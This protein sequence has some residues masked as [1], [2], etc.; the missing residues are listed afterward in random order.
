MFVLSDS[1][2]KSLIKKGELEIIPEPEGVAFQPSS[3]DLRIG[4][5]FKQ[6][7]DI[8]IIEIT[9]NYQPEDYW[10]T[11]EEVES[12]GD[13][14]TLEKNKLYVI[15]SLEKIKLSPDYF[16]EFQQRSS[17]GRRFCFANSFSVGSLDFSF[18]KFSDDKHK[19]VE[20]CI[21]PFT[22]TKIYKGQRAFQL[23]VFKNPTNEDSNNFFYDEIKLHAGEVFELKEDVE[24]DT[25]KKFEIE[26]YYEKVKINKIEP[27]KNYLVKTDEKVKISRHTAGLILSGPSTKMA[28]EFR[29]DI[30]PE[31]HDIDFLRNYIPLSFSCFNA[32]FVDPGYEGNLTL[33]PHPN[34]FPIP[35]E[36]PLGLLR[37]FPVKGKVERPYGSKGL[38]S[39][40][41]KRN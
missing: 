1:Y 39:K 40:Y 8:K 12:N 41:V 11:L 32:G 27:G 5:V 13:C 20:Y 14:Y 24:I 9:D 16:L 26:E 35:I 4:K 19:K 7:D 28:D 33:Q 21:Y 30:P 6:K 3:I 31:W 22:K 10:N 23:I 34:L 25:K 15:E 36:R 37:I 29:E 2:L 18:G 17:G 38:D